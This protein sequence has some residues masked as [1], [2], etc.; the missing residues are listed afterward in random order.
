M[1]NNINIILLILLGIA[2]GII[3]SI[4]PKTY[5]YGPPAKP[6]AVKPMS[7]NITKALSHHDQKP[8]VVFSITRGGN[9]QVFVPQGSKIITPKF[10]LHANNIVN[11]NSITL[12]ETSNPKFCWTSLNGDTECVVW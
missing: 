7:S 8:V 2:I 5:N 6:G 12:F 10:P 4:Y 9:M 3:Y 1:K 11:I